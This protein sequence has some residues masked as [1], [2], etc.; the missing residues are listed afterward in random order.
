MLNQVQLKYIS[1]LTKNIFIFLLNYLGV[2]ICY[3]GAMYNR[4]D[5]IKYQVCILNHINSAWV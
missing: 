2:E 5:I 3:C 4:K 1:L